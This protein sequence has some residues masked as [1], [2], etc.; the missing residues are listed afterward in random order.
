MAFCPT[1]PPLEHHRDYVTAQFGIEVLGRE[2]DKPFF[3][4]VGFHKPH[5]PFVAPKRFFDLYKDGIEAPPVKADD[6]TDV[7][8]PGRRVGGRQASLPGVSFLDRLER[9]PCSGSAGIEPLQGQHDH[10]AVI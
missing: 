3:L 10:S 4:A 5:L 9:R 2:H 8:W 7:S 6:L 1:R